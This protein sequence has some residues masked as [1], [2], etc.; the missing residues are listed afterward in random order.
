MAMCY[1]MPTP[2][3]LQ[4]YIYMH[5]LT[6]ALAEFSIP[7]SLRFSQVY[8]L[9]LSCRSPAATFA[10]RHGEVLVTQ[11]TFALC[12]AEGKGVSNLCVRNLRDRASLSHE[13]SRNCGPGVMH[14]G[15]Q[16]NIKKEM[17]AMPASLSFFSNNHYIRLFRIVYLPFKMNQTV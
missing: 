3:T 5:Y 9:T 8:F 12:S 7:V 6:C 2:S 16:F 10:L 4:L 14:P 13:F 11:S 15:L 17:P 1:S